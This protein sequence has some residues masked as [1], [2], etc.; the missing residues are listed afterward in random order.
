MVYTQRYR[1]IKVELHDGLYQK[2]QCLTATEINHLKH[3][4][5]FMVLIANCTKNNVTMNDR[6]VVATASDHLDIIAELSIT[7]AEILD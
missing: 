6:Q 3:G 2:H 5:P 4:P 1:L 7:H